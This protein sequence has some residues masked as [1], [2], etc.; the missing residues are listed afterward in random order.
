MAQGTRAKTTATDLIEASATE[1][2]DLI[3]HRDVSSREVVDAHIDRIER[4]NPLI[5]AL[6]NARFDEARREAR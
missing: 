1:L 3:H 6:A 4:V 2:A 5:N